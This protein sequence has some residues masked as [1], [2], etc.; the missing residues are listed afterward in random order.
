MTARL[1]AGA[2]MTAN[3]A[4]RQSTRV[5]MAMARMKVRLVS[6]QYMTPRFSGALFVE[7]H[8]EEVVASHL[9]RANGMPI[10]KSRASEVQS[11]L[12]V[13]HRPLLVVVVVR[14]V[15]LLL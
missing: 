1:T 5:M 8:R 10:L 13:C 9:I 12:Y 3:M 7:Q 4:R 6:N 11:R 2:G 14:G 15:A